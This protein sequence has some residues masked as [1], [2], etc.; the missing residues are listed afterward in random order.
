MH[1]DYVALAKGLASRQLVPANF[2]FKDLV[3]KNP[4]QDYY[5]SIY[6]YRDHHV[7]KFK[8][9]RSLAGITDVT[10]NLLVFDFDDKTD[11]ESARKDAVTL[12]ERLQKSGVDVNNIQCFFSGG[13]G[14]GIE[15]VTDQEF[16]RQEFVNI[17]FGLAGDLK[18]FDTTINDEQR[19]LR[20]P[21]SRHPKTGLYK[22]PL[23]IEDLQLMDIDS[24]KGAAA[25]NEY[26]IPEPSIQTMTESLNVLKVTEYKRVAEKKEASPIE[27]DFDT[28]SIDWSQVPKWLSPERFVLQEGYFRGSETAA[29]GQRNKAFL[30]LAA[31]YRN[32]GFSYD[33]TL[34]L[35]MA[36][37]ERQAKRTGESPYTE[38][39]MKREIL[40][41]VFSP[42]WKG[43]IYG[44]DDELLTAIR[45]HFGIEDGQSEDLNLVKIE[46]VGNK[47]KKF[48]ENFHQNRIF[49]GIESLDKKL[50]LTTS[51]A[52]GILGAPSS[53]KTSILN[54]IVE[55]QSNK[56]IPTV[57][58]SLDMGDN[59]LYLRLL[60]KYSRLPIEVIME[61]FQSG[62]PSP[63]LKE[64]YANVLKNYTN[65]H[66]NFRSAMTVEAIDKDISTYIKETG[67]SPRV[68]AIDYLEKV[69]SE[70]SDPTMASGLVVSQL[71]DLAKKYE[72]LVLVLL[73][74]QKSAGAPDAE[75]LS[76]RKVKGASQIEQDLRCI[77]TVWRPG[78]N[79]KDNSRDKYLSM[80]VVKNNLGETCQLDFRW[81][82]ITGRIRELEQE[83]RRD[84]KLL[85]EEIAAEKAEID[86]RWD[87]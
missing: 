9:T 16:T 57:Y 54:N 66:F 13:K 30:I 63:E 44:R 60:Q 23:S 5:R 4:N 11:I 3:R 55:H 15:V 80:A 75:L 37:A 14:F 40:A 87:I 32:Q 31:T 2:N 20:V 47:F 79:P 1:M 21:L 73:Q 72:A 62:D 81:E 68:I 27:L 49:T 24:I 64:A 58:Q 84:L 38:E 61:S 76:M 41:E 26:E 39:Q 67:R 70:F 52:V 35:L 53:G 36:T 71:S 43:G 34:G 45:E 65:V 78:F 69:R 22:I 42:N 50:V 7:S 51:M 82:G 59:L 83:E 25:D 77:M 86:N 48:A 10:T 56:G 18:T 29:V 85:R 46:D 17:V 12:C 28:K 8:E 6:K 19:I 74:P 33:H